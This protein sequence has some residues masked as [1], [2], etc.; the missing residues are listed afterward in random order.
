MIRPEFL[1]LGIERYLEATKE[2]AA[3]VPGAFAV[4][5]GLDPAQPIVPTPLFRFRT[6]ENLT[7]A[8][9]AALES[10]ESR[11]IG[12]WFQ[13]EVA[14]TALELEPEGDAD[15]CQIQ[16]VGAGT[17]VRS[18]I[19]AYEVLEAALAADPREWT[20]WFARFETPG[21]RA[22]LAATEH[23][24]LASPA[25]PAHLGVP[26]GVVPLADFSARFQVVP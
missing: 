20:V 6:Y 17:Q 9:G 22:V 18:W 26:G 21:I 12:F 1:S 23:E 4:A 24:I 14:V 16:R 15:G 25:G 11:A 10:E 8:L 19:E 7:P 3:K 2:W 13:H 5:L